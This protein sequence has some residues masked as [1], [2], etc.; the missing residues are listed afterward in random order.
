MRLVSYARG[1]RLRHR[2]LFGLTKLLS[3]EVDDVAKV[4]MKRPRFFGKAFLRLAQAVLRGPS[5]WTVGERELFGAVVSR[6]NDCPFCVGIHAGIAAEEIGWD[7][8]AWEDGRA[9]PRA[10][11]TCR[12]VDK[13]TR[14]PASLSEQDV[15]TAR[16]AG[17]SDS[18]LLEAIYVA[19]MFNLINRVANA[20]EF[21]Q[22]SALSQRAGVTMLRRIG[23]RLPGTFLCDEE[24]DQG[25]SPLESGSVQGDP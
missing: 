11:A 22:A 7:P 20:L 8:F 6:A 19:S 23:Y 21:T 1:N 12:F 2:V 9:G 3:V 10:T 25:I 13:L 17:V 24:L 4:V 18:A 16:A 14:D 15:A 5:A